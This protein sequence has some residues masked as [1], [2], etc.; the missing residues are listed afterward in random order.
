MYTCIHTYI[1]TYIQSKFTP[2]KSESN[3]ISQVRLK[4]VPINN[5]DRS[6]GGILSFEAGPIGQQQQI[7]CIGDI[8]TSK[9]FGAQ[10]CRFLVF[11][12]FL[13]LFPLPMT[14]G[15]PKF[16]V[17]SEKHFRLQRML[18]L[19]CRSARSSGQK[20]CQRPI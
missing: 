1:H 14:E 16:G 18:R 11:S 10:I 19:P 20:D 12:C 17:Y 3:V 6:V 15:K 7:W 4:G 2:E 13:F 8:S 9:H 5:V